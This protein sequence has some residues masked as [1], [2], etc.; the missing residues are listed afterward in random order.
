MPTGTEATM[1]SFSVANTGNLV[2]SVFGFMVQFVIVGGALWTVWGIV[3]L[4][5]ALKDK[6]GPGLQGGVWQIVGGIMILVS[7]ILFGQLIKLQ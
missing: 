1:P 3:V 2:N 6:N 4:A 5:G 7:A